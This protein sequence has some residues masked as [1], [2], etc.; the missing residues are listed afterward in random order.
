MPFKNIDSQM[1]KKWL[2]NNEAVLVDVREPSEYSAKNICGSVLIPLGTILLGVLPDFADKKLVIH[3][4]AGK[5][6]GIACEKLLAQDPDLEI[7][8]LEGGLL[9]WEQAGFGVSSFTTKL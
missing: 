8:N 9:A 3:C 5:R 7:Y 1:L 2:D 6:G 4:H